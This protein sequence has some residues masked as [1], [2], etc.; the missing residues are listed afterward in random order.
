MGL[1]SNASN[2]GPFSCLWRISDMLLSLIASNVP[3]M[4]KKLEINC[5]LNF[6]S[7]ETYITFK[8]NI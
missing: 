5:F 8:L 7:H 1:G 6:Y 4:A 2:K 3:K